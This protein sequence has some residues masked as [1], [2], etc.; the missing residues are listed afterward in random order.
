MQVFQFIFDIIG[1]WFFVVFGAPFINYEVLWILTPV[2]LSWIFTEFFQE[3]S[4]TSIGNAISNGV[5]ALWAGMDWLR[6]TTR[7]WH[8]LSAGMAF[9]LVA[10]CVVVIGYGLFIIVNGMKVKEIVKYVGR[11]R[12]VTYVVMMFTPLLQRTMRTNAPE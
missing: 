5:V 4:G 9:G 3:K 7:I 8:T 2:Y 12:E 1:T 6:T 10:I 11:I